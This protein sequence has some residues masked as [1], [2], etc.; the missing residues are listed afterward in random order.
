VDLVCNA[1][2][3]PPATIE[4]T[5]L[6]GAL[7]PIGQEKK[8]VSML[9]SFFVQ[10]LRCTVCT[11]CKDTGYFHSDGPREPCI[12]CEPRFPQEKGQFGSIPGA[13]WSFV[14]ILPCQH[15]PLDKG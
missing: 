2:A 6:G 12:R 14:K 10:F 15:H 4:W 1:T 5:R 11:E 3:R 9:F 13:M 7:L 8:L